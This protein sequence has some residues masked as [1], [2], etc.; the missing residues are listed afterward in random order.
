MS[1]TRPTTI[2][3]ISDL[4][5][6]S[7]FDIRR[8]GG[9]DSLLNSLV[10]DLREV[11]DGKSP[12]CIVVSG[13]LTTQG[14]PEGHVAALEF[15]VDLTAKLKLRRKDVVIVP[16]NHEIN[17]KELELNYEDRK[18][19]DELRTAAFASYQNNLFNKFYGLERVDTAKSWFTT[20][21][22]DGKVFVLGLNSCMIDGPDHPGVGYVDPEQ[23]D[24]ALTRFGKKWDRCAVRIAVV[25]HH[26]VPVTWMESRPNPDRP[27]LTL[28]TER[29]LRWLTENGFQAVLHGHQHQ[30]FCAAEVRFGKPQEDD[31]RRF[32][33]SEIV[34]LGAGSVSV[35][36]I[37]LGHIGQNHYQLLSVIP[38]K[39]E[40]HSR[41][42]DGTMFTKFGYHQRL[43]IPLRPGMNSPQLCRVLAHLETQTNS[44]LLGTVR[45]VGSGTAVGFPRDSLPSLY[46]SILAAAS[47]KC[48]GTSLLISLQSADDDPMF[49]SSH[50]EQMDAGSFRQLFIAA[51]EDCKKRK[52]RN[53]LSKLS[54]K[55][56]KVKVISDVAYSSIAKTS[57]SQIFDTLVS[58]YPTFPGITSFRKALR[59][60]RTRLM[61]AIFGE[62]D[63]R[64]IGFTFDRSDNTKGVT[65][66]FQKSSFVVLVFEPPRNFLSLVH[67]L[68]DQAWTTASSL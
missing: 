56:L 6:G 13:D 40:L 37:R 8:L 23:M 45:R 2:L 28:N 43:L 48:I 68:L 54:L 60:D 50:S 36:P 35:K 53:F 14:Q 25:H 31:S 4:H 20:D 22:S 44:K 15:L 18:P 58:I 3:H 11:N 30:P 19:I 64:F 32:A 59:S 65:T 9:V 5:F 52:V 57:M 55:G 7:D 46:P 63:D 42:A 29:V 66:R 38:G 51:E 62:E 1:E 39:I 67:E 47:N 12:H 61:L 16:G 33:R 17:W 49:S 27:S 24:D 41:K 21:W 34:L 26:L 10:R